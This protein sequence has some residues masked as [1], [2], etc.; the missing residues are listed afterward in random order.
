M[1]NKITVVGYDA[2]ENHI[3]LDDCTS[4]LPV[5]FGKGNFIMP[6]ILLCRPDKEIASSDSSFP[7][8]T[9]SGTLGNYLSIMISHHSGYTAED[10][11]TV[12]TERYLRED[13]YRYKGTDGQIKDGGKSGN[14]VTWLYSPLRARKYGISG[15]YT[16]AVSVM[17]KAGNL[18]PDVTLD[19]SI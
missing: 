11:M 17:D 18:V 6:F 16:I 14:E 2:K 3:F 12:I 5:G 9:L 13:V 19:L 10:A 4:L 15:N 7:T 1:N 8:A